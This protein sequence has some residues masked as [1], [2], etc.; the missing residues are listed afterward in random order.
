RFNLNQVTIQ[1][2]GLSL[3]GDGF[4]AI[5]TGGGQVMATLTDVILTSNRE[6]GLRFD[7]SGGSSM[8]IQ[9]D[10]IIGNTNGRHGLEYHVSTGSS[11]NLGATAS[12]FSNN[13]TAFVGNG[14]WATANGAGSLS[15]GIF[16]GVVADN[17]NRMGF[18]FDVRSGA[19]LAGDIR[20]NALFGDS[21]GSG[22]GIN[23]VRFNAQDAGTMGFLLMSGPNTFDNNVAGDGIN[24]D[25]VGVNMAV[26]QVSGSVNGNGADGI[27]IRMINVDSGAIAL[28]G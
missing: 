4:E 3:V 9:M 10:S 18:E 25:A 8:L 14:V 23:G 27:N 15:N 5:A 19:T 28:S 20:S 16:Q 12:S 17:N 26:A 24:Y 13:G 22:N 1:Q 7:A 6:S 2:N 21:S 11:I